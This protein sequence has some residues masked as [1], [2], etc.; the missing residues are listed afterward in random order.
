MIHQTSH[1]RHRSI[2]ADPIA[3][4]ALSLCMG[5]GTATSLGCTGAEVSLGS[6]EAAIESTE[7]PCGNGVVEGDEECDDGNTVGG[8]GCSA[9]CV[10][11]PA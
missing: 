11:E 9:Y 10:C 2:F 6:G 4:R 5:L 1:R 7:G 3:Q 8:D